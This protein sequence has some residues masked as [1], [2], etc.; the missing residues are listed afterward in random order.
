MRMEGKS[1]VVTGA[2]SGM[3]REIVNLFVREGAKVV[4]VARRRERLEE[5]A[6]S[7]RDAPGSLELYPGDVSLREVSEGMIDFAVERFGHLDALI[8]NAGVMD[9]MSPI[10][11]V[12]DERYEK[13][14]KINVY[15]P[16]C[17]MR[18]AVNV[19]KAQGGG[20]CIVNVA[21]IGAM[22]TAAGA[23]YGGSKAALVAMSKNT[24]FMYIPDGIRC[25]VIAPGG[26]KTEIGSSMG[27]PNMAGYG[28]VQKVLA[29]APEPG[30][31]VEIAR[32]A[33]FLCS[34]EAAYITG[35]VL[36]VDGGWTAG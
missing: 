2:S 36:V 34:D 24:A 16:M 15:G 20:G 30:D 19:F 31:P 25:N 10:G 11:D 18:R 14:M 13:I 27:V 9:D 23:L 7:L 1:V 26:F 4:A 12:T 29:T 22:R 21:S 3:G 32:A 35:D 33:L 6:E 28:R 17:S 5:L 8:N